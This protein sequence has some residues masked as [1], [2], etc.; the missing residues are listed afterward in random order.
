VEARRADEDLDGSRSKR[1]RVGVPEDHIGVVGLAYV[2]QSVS[3][4]SGTR[5]GRRDGGE[6]EVLGET[7]VVGLLSFEEEVS[8]VKDGMVALHDD[9]RRSSYQHRCRGYCL[10][11]YSDI[12]LGEDLGSVLASSPGLAL[13]PRAVDPD[14][15][16]IDCKIW[17]Y[18]SL[19]W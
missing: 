11:T 6:S 10:W 19:T 5:G 18:L 3:E 13:V 8:R 14:V 2:S 7:K 4:S 17:R 12:I 9:L 16:S 15:V 1:E